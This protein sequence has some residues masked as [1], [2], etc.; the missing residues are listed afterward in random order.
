MACTGA[1]WSGSSRPRL[2]AVSRG[3]SYK[4]RMLR[5]LEIENF[6][7]FKHL[8]VEGLGRVNLI[9]GRNDSGKTSLMGAAAF[10]RSPSAL[11][12]W[13][14]MLGHGNLP[15]N[16]LER[17][18]RPLFRGGTNGLPIRFVSVDTKLGPA[19]VQISL[20]TGGGANTFGRLPVLF[21]WTQS[22][23]TKKFKLLEGDVD[24]PQSAIQLDNSHA[25]WSGPYPD[26]EEELV[27]A[28]TEIYKTGRLSEIGELVRAVQPAVQRV[29]LAGQA[30]YV[31]LN[32][33]PLPLPLSVLG[34]GAR[35]LLE[36][37]IA[38]VSNSTETFI[39]EIEN[40]FH[41]STLPSVWK[42]LQR[43]PVNQIFAT[44]HREE[45]IRFACEVFQEA[46][47]DGLRIIRVD[48]TPDGHRAV[49]YTPSMA[50]DAL[51]SGLEIRG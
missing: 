15:Y 25:W 18:W 5:S 8:K 7:G 16:D 20:T 33:H 41:Y 45:N 2:L 28:L 44:T 9:I 51:D 50:L 19:I 49:V 46:G 48:R 27:D 29:E 3:D 1:S 34:D 21:N 14:R 47:D 40:G 22:G 39:D 4:L 6:R 12:H 38:V 31:L 26:P 32:G 43:S 35:R 42:L 11:V 37:A 36:F 13:A 30:I 24:I 23:K 17:V 10:A